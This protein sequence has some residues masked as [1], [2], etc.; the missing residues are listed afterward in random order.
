MAKKPMTPDPEQTE[1]MKRAGINFPFIWL[2]VGNF[3]RSFMVKN[4]ITGEVKLI[5]KV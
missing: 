5:D 3:S 2:V 4:T 1:L